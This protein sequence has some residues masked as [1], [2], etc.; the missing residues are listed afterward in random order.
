MSSLPGRSFRYP[1][2][3]SYLWLDFWSS[4]HVGNKNNS[5]ALS[6]L[7]NSFT[8]LESLSILHSLSSLSIFLLLPHVTLGSSNP[9]HQFDSIITPHSLLLPPAS[10]SPSFHSYSATAILKHFIPPSPVLA[11]RV[12]LVPTPQTS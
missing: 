9:F 6:S 1:T 11:L 3:S 7:L 12:L 2:S 10:V 8:F 4:Q 5:Q